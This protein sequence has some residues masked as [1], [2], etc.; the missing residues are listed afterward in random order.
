MPKKRLTQVHLK[1]TA[2]TEEAKEQEKVI[3]VFV[4]WQM[5]EK[6]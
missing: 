1:M 2:K 5:V 4:I 6:S 3:F